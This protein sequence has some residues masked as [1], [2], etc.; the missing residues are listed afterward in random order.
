MTQD[1]TLKEKIQENVFMFLC[2]PI[3]DKYGYTPVNLHD[4]VEKNLCC[5]FRKDYPY[6]ELNFKH[7]VKIN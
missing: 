5:R 6:K 4:K 2:Q 7:C 1:K 3:K